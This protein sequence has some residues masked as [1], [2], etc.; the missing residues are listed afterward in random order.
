MGA[1]VANVINNNNN[2]NN[3]T[4]LKKVGFKIKI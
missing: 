1:R 2:N 4:H 3:K